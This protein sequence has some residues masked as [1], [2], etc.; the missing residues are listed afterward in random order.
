[1][2]ATP[3]PSTIAKFSYKLV[4][5]EGLTGLIDTLPG[6]QPEQREFIKKRWLHQVVWWDRRSRS[7]R[8]RYF[9]L[10][11]VVVVVGVAI[12]ALVSLDLGDQANTNKQYAIIGLSLLVAIC[13]AVEG[14]FNFGETW[15][16]KR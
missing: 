8:W 5:E 14:L 2:N 11:G 16:E 3:K 6:L 15:R 9:L 4:D 13:A 7:A 12:P 10:R 1:M